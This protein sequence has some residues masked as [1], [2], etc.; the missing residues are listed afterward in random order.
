MAGDVRVHRR[1][2]SL[3][4]MG[5]RDGMA[6]SGVDP[7]PSD[8]PEAGFALL[9]RCAEQRPHRAV[10]DSLEAGYYPGG[11]P[12]PFLFSRRVAR[13]AAVGCALMAACAGFRSKR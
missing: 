6:L 8:G 1:K 11:R 4:P 10:S 3:P 9:E 2:I 5:G 12:A 13:L 7:T